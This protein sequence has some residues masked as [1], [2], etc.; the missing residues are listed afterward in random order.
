MFKI[1]GAAIIVV[2]TTAFGFGGVMRLGS[3]VRNLQSLIMA[4]EVMKNEICERLTPMPELLEM[5]S[6]ETDAP[7]NRIFKSCYKQMTALGSQ[8]FYFIW[9]AA[10][11]GTDGLELT[12]D[13]TKTLTDMGHVLG[14]YDTQEQRAAFSYATRR[15]EGFLRYA[16]DEKRSQ[17]KVQ[18]ALGVAAGIFVVIILI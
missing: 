3:R 18:A 9:K 16:V 7:I 4:L 2:C 15:L 10:I 17:G 11:E 8:S 12:A 1:I 5:L 6:K 13:E 14:R